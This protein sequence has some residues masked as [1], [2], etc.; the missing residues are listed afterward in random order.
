[1]HAGSSYCSNLYIAKSIMI[2]TEL[3][4]RYFVSFYLMNRTPSWFSEDPYQCYEKLTRNSNSSSSVWYQP[5]AIQVT[6]IATACMHAG[7]VADYKVA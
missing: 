2:I 1:M 6:A 7:A 5:A 3:W 4:S